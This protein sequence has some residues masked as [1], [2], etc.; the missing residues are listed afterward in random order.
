MLPPPALLSM[1]QGTQ[2]LNNANEYA[3]V[4]AEIVM[5]GESDEA[6]SA[7]KLRIVNKLVPTYIDEDEIN[8]IKDQV[9]IDAAKKKTA[10]DD[11]SAY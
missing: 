11:N 2:L 7:F 5:A 3:N 4:M 9:R 8:N 10:G 6:K 1:T